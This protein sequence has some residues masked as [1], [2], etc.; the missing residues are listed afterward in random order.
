MTASYAINPKMSNFTLKLLE[1]TGWYKPN[2]TAAVPLTW[3]YKRGCE[4]IQDYCIDST[5]KKA[6]FEEFCSTPNQL[7]CSLDRR[8]KATCAVK[9]YTGNPGYSSWNYFG[10]GTLGTDPFAD[11]CLYPMIEPSGK[12]CYYVKGTSKLYDEVAGVDSRCFEGTLVKSDF[13]PS[14]VGNAFCFNYN[15]IFY[16]CKPNIIKLFDIK[17][18]CENLKFMGIV[19]QCEQ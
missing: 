14:P 7:S 2:Y 10:N 19:S 11:N 5:T 9:P 6:N 17:T 18:V 1:S 4:F 12:D 8:Y 3:G 15:V 13:D 16:L